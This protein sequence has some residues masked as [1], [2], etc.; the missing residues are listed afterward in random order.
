MSEQ[1]AEIDNQPW[2]ARN[3]RAITMLMLI[4]IVFNNFVLVPYAIALGFP[5]VELKIPE[6]MWT[7]LHIGL[8]GYLA[9]QTA[10]NVAKTMKEK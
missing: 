4:F 7:L 10:E 3:W 6:D 5:I 8:G 1:V 2:I 9:K